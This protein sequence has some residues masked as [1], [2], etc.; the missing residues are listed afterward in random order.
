MARERRAG[1]RALARAASISGQRPTESV[2]YPNNSSGGIYSV[3]SA[4]GRPLSSPLPLPSPPG[5]GSPAL[6]SVECGDGR[7]GERE[8]EEE[9]KGHGDW[10]RKRQSR[11]DRPSKNLL[12]F[13]LEYY[14]LQGERSRIVSFLLWNRENKKG[15]SGGEGSVNVLGKLFPPSPNLPPFASFVRSISAPL[16]QNLQ[17]DA[18]NSVSS[19][20]SLSTST[21][22]LICLFVYFYRH[23]LLPLQTFG[24]SF[25]TLLSIWNRNK[26]LL[27]GIAGSLFLFFH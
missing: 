18:S 15:R 1:T 22:S 12:Y 10:E 24:G 2:L 23:C 5:T 21:Y 11:V 9:P 16:L 13:V 27:C 14:Q 3:S 6:T 25:C 17:L 20:S 7:E 26:V 19:S 4:E 8:G